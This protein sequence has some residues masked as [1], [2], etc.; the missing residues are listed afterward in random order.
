MA[1]DAPFI[2]EKGNV[3]A[4]QDVIAT[5][6]DGHTIRGNIAAC[7]DQRGYLLLMGHIVLV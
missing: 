1:L 2:Y 3:P 7:F 5:G 6:V 4:V